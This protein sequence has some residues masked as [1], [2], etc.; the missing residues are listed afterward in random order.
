[1]MA[2]V[3]AAI[4]AGLLCLVF[5][6]AA[7][8]KWGAR[9]EFAGILADYRLLPAHA[10]PAIAVLLPAVEAFTAALLVLPASRGASAALALALLLAYAA[11]MGWNLLHGR[12][13]I[14][15][16]C[17]GPAQAIS[18]L[19]VLRNVWLAAV[20]SLALWLPA[21]PDGAPSDL[22]MAVATVACVGVLWLLVLLFEQLLGN[23]SH[24]ATAFHSRY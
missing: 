6:R 17:G 7:L 19:H 5:L 21:R 16:G 2:A 12:I 9:E 18:W 11:A 3:A 15:C 13:A 23:R 4:S 24:A 22:A 10:V 20:A 14:D 1:M 8:H